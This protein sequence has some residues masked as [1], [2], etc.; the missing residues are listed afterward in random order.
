MNYLLPVNKLNSNTLDN[1]NKKEV[2]N[3]LTQ[4]L[5]ICQLSNGISYTDTENMDV[6]ERT[7]IF[8]KLIQMEKEKNDAKLKAIEAAKTRS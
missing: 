1:M 2:E 3:I 7:F 6:Y 8:K 4:Q 5:L